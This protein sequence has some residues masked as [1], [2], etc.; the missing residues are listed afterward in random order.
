VGNY[1]AY[2]VDKWIEEQVPQDRSLRHTGEN[3][4]RRRKSTRNTDLRCP[5][6][7]VAT[8]PVYTAKMH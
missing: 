2:V 1:I 6:R 7:Q 4:E 8:K 5:V 3:Y